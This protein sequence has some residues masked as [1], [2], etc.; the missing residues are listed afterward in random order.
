MGIRIRE[1]RKQRVR[2]Y[3]KNLVSA[4][5]APDCLTKVWNRVRMDF[6]ENFILEVTDP[7][8]S[9]LENKIWNFA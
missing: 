3:N 9:Y 6:I 7:M 1:R 8:V 5:M 4:A 2:K